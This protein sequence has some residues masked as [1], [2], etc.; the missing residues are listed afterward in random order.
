MADLCRG[1][2]GAMRYLDPMRDLLAVPATPEALVPALIA[3]W[4]GTGPAILPYDPELEGQAFGRLFA[5]MQ[6]SSTLKPGGPVNLPFGRGVPDDVV[7]VIQ[8]SGSTG[9]PRGVQLTRAALEA[10]VK[11][12]LAR[13]DADPSIPWLCVLPLHHI[14]GLLTVLRGVVSGTPTVIHEEFDPEA[15]KALP[16]PHHMSLVPTMALRLAE[17]GFTQQPGTVVM[18]GGAAISQRV[19]DAWPDAVRTWGMTET[20]GGCVYNGEPLDGVSVLATPSGRLRIGGP[21]VMA[22]YRVHTDAGR[23][24]T[25]GLAND[26][27]MELGEGLDPD[28][29]FTSADLGEVR[30]GVVTVYGRADDVI[31]T[32][33]EKVIAGQIAQVLEQLEDVEEAAV[34]GIPDEEWGQ[35][36]VAVMVPVDATS[37]GL[38]GRLSLEV[39][40][41]HVKAALGAPAAPKDVLVVRSMPRLG[42]GKVDRIGL[43]ATVGAMLTPKPSE[44][45]GCGGGCCGSGGCGSSSEAEEATPAPD[46]TPDTGTNTEPEAKESCGGGGCGGGGCGGH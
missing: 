24:I 22:G 3:A 44:G 6:P 11:G 42:N 38:S 21:T 35:R 18:I 9:E 26:E 32:G 12:G 2:F 43:T 28:G 23:G 37:P 46:A 34:V 25:N 33:G 20:A 45:G 30:D 5:A 17:A 27:G 29:W 8:T 13:T 16:G 41:D 31:N 40:R 15:I 36:V 4:E 19:S 1:G 10:S 7:M 39:V 14:A